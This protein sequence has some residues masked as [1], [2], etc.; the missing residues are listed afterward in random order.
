MIRPNSLALALASAG[1]MV[2]APA[3]AQASETKFP[4]S[5]VSAQIFT[6][7]SVPTPSGP[8]AFNITRAFLTGKYR[9]NQMWSGTLTV[10]PFPQ[11]YVTGVTNGTA[12]TG[13]EAHDVVLQHAFI[14]ADGI[15]PGGS[16]QL[17][18]LN[19]PWTDY[20]FSHWGLRLLGPT[21]I[22]GGLGTGANKNPP[23]I[24]PYDKGLR[25]NGDHGLV[26]Y[27]LAVINGEGF[28]SSEISGQKTYTGR[29][30]LVPVDG[31]DVTLL[32]Q[33]GNP[34]GAQQSDRLGFLL[35]YKVPAFRTAVEGIR[36][37]DTT[38]KGVATTGQILTA[39]GAVRMP[40]PVPMPVELFVRGDHVDA[41]IDQANDDRLESVVGISVTPVKG[42][43]FAL[44]NQNI[45]KNT[46][47]GTVN[48]NVIGLHSMLKF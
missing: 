37:Y 7:Y 46:A 11:S 22:A 19:H 31:V 38:S 36:L 20:E 6:D 10:T 27:S 44:N 17:G 33:I 41:N 24:A 35:G 14:Q 21:P 42:V 45:N 1:T 18:M 26:H 25:L 8:Q 28:R 5:S 23:L 12:A 39:Y 16:F 9:F 4:S 48:S 43:V 2:A 32:G 29:L 30:T 13:T 3:F 15:Y 47:K 40:A 34:S